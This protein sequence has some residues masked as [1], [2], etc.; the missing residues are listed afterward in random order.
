MYYYQYY[1][2]YFIDFNCS[3]LCIISCRLHYSLTHSL[4]HFSSLCYLW[5]SRFYFVQSSF[6]LS[7]FLDHTFFAYCCYLMHINP[8]VILCLWLFPNIRTLARGPVKLNKFLWSICVEFTGAP[9]P[10]LLCIIF[11]TKHI[12]YLQHIHVYWWI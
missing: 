1:L 8:V 4:P 11:V 2:F 7:S 5:N 10:K 12:L 9:Q 3:L 6:Y